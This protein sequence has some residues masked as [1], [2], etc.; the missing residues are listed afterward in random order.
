[1]FR[2]E[3]I[4]VLWDALLTIGADRAWRSSLGH[5]L[6]WT[7]DKS[8]DIARLTGRY[9]P[10]DHG[11]GT[12]LQIAVEA[13]IFFTPNYNRVTGRVSSVWPSYCYVGDKRFEAHVK[14]W[15]V[16]KRS[17]ALCPKCLSVLFSEAT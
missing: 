13:S 7:S 15:D 5:V 16:A 12:S 4:E 6:L 8:G 2:G 3:D 10:W 17:F 14:E 11:C 1:M 9:Q